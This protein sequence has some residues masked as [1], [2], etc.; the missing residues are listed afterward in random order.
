MGGWGLNLKV[1][2]ETRGKGGTDA[3]FWRAGFDR[4]AEFLQIWAV[5]CVS[6]R[7]GSKHAAANRL[8]KQAE[9]SFIPTR[10]SLLTKLKDWDD[11]ESWKR[12]H[13]TYWKLIFSVAVKAGLSEEEAKDVV[14]ETVIGVAQKMKEFKYDPAVG[15]FKAWLLTLTR[16]RI[17]DQMRKRN[18]HQQRHVSPA[19][20]ASGTA[21]IDK[22]PD[23]AS[24]ALDLVWEE[25]WQK[26]LTDVALS[27]IR[28]KVNAK[29]YQIF[30]LYVIKEWS[31]QEVVETL[32]VS[33]HQVYG[34]K[35]RLMALLEKEVEVLESQML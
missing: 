29:D 35:S 18:R 24:L 2:K 5:H 10:R 17:M 9:G 12:F 16:W 19:E 22:V 15:S 32:H 7:Y 6:I 30:D 13:D 1:T 33:V 27:R 11:Q 34:A 3:S 20:D 28:R 14:Q 31:V 23:P 4:F 25:Q 8:M 26:N 21:L